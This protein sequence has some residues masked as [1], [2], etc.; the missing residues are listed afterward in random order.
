MHSAAAIYCEIISYLNPDLHN[1]DYLGI[2]SIDY[3]SIH[4]IGNGGR[5]IYLSSYRAKDII[6]G[7]KNVGADVGS[8]HSERK[9]ARI[10]KFTTGD[11]KEYMTGSYMMQYSFVADANPKNP[12]VDN[13]KWVERS[14]DES[15]DFTI[16]K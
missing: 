1:Y 11:G 7:A 3:A 5:Q 9:M 12:N 10:Y 13:D 14:L 2:K 15:C 8:T 6:P 16:T 4:D